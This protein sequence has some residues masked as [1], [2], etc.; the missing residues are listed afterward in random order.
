MRTYSPALAAANQPCLNRI[1][2]NIELVLNEAFLGL[3][4]DSKLAFAM[5]G[6]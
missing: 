3:R 5:V 6:P 2:I 4:A 1:L